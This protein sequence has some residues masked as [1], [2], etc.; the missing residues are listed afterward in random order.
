VRALLCLTLVAVCGG[1]LDITPADGALRCSAGSRQ[2]PSGYSCASDNT[3]W[4]NPHAG[5]GG[6]DMTTA[7]G[8]DGGGG[9]V[10][11]ML[12]G[13]CAPP[14]SPCLLQAC[15][16]NVCALVAA[17]AKTELADALQSAHDCQKLVCDSSGASTSV[18]DSSDV[19]LD[20]SGGCNTPSCDG[21]TPVLT[22]TAAGS[23]CTQLQSGVCNGT[24]TCGA[25]KPGA[26]QC[27][28]ST[29]Q[30]LCDSQG[31]W[32]DHLTCMGACSGGVCTGSCNA[33]NYQPNCVGTTLQTCSNNNVVGMTCSYACCNGGCTGS[34]APNTNTCSS[35]STRLSCDACGNPTTTTCSAATPYCLNGNCV[36]C[37]PGTAQCCGDGNAAHARTC[38]AGGAWGSCVSCG[39]N[40]SATYT[41][42]TA[43][44]TAINCACSAPDPCATW[45]CGSG[46]NAC[47][48]SV[49]CG[50]C[51][52]NEACR[53]HHCEC[54]TC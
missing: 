20:A 4:R 17:P 10:S 39:S 8:V 47:G 22:P 3:C 18:A 43:S 33:T 28:D 32:N 50:G 21:P 44:A 38:D 9:E 27:H 51:G 19:P 37:Q 24:G 12:P 6:G 42:S 54:A 34:C 31:Q 2:C 11:C 26:T 40:S 16:G 49:S 5:N 45:T 46:A 41:C 30:Q 48:Q 29:V 36:A 7:G 15:I 13:D 1:C 25:C 35:T 14:P 23:A 53:A 52:A